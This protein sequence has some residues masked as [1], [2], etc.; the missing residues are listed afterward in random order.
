MWHYYSK[1]D[2]KEI[3]CASSVWGTVCLKFARGG[4]ETSAASGTQEWKNLNKKRQEKKKNQESSAAVTGIAWFSINSYLA[5]P[6]E[7]G[8]NTGCPA[9][10]FTPSFP[11]VTPHPIWARGISDQGQLIL[12]TQLHGAGPHSSHC[13]PAIWLGKELS[14]HT[15]VL[16]NVQRKTE[17]IWTPQ[18]CAVSCNL[19]GYTFK[20][21]QSY[22]AIRFSSL[23]MK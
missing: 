17:D 14:E 12:L 5:L 4:L 9:T 10:S 13:L 6:V 1:T 16:T 11:E 8:L 23:P 20:T 7:V 19:V 3:P 15:S 18:A 22:Q 21:V 2:S